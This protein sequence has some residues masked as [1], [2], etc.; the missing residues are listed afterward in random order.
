MEPSDQQR[1]SH[2][3]WLIKGEFHVETS[4][5]WSGVGDRD[6]QRLAYRRNA[7]SGSARRHLCKPGLRTRRQRM[8]AL[9]PALATLGLGVPAAVHGELLLQPVAV[10]WLLIWRSRR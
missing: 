6:R 4:H 1:V 3:W 10:V 2:P 9:E 8:L 7:R 5:D